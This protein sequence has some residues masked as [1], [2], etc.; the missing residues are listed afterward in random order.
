MSSSFLSG[1]ELLIVNH[2]TKMWHESGTDFS[3]RF[4]RCLHVFS[5]LLTHP[6]NLRNKRKNPS[7]I[8]SCQFNLDLKGLNQFQALGEVL[9][10]TLALNSVFVQQ[11]FEHFEDQGLVLNI[12]RNYFILSKVTRNYLQPQHISS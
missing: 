7:K 6:S 5:L 4:S 8:H 9:A 2:I 11:G 12:L 10:F 1:L 3:C